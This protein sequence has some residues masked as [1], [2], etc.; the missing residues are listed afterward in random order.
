MATQ[1]QY[2]PCGQPLPPR[3]T[4]G[5]PRR[6]CSKPCGDRDYERTHPNRKHIR[7]RSRTT[8]TPAMAPDRYRDLKPEAIERRIAAAYAHIRRV[9]LPPRN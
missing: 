5:R 9:G 3:P 7:T 4:G 6:Y 2:P 1:C 8:R